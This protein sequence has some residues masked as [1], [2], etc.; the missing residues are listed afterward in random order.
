MRRL[1]SLLLFVSSL[2]WADT[3]S[4]L[5]T[6]TPGVSGAGVWTGIGGYSQLGGQHPITLWGCCTSYSGS[7]PFYDTATWGGNGQSGQFIWSYGQATVQQIIAVN[8]ALANVGAG[9]QISGYNWGYDVRN[10]NGNDGQS[11]YSDVLTATTFMTNTAGAN[12]LSDTRT[13]SGAMEWTRFTGTVS[14]ATPID[15]ANAGVLG[16]KFSSSDAGFW[17]G[18]YGPQVRD[19]S[20]SL[21]YTAAPVDPCVADPQSSPTC[22][23]YR[24]YYTMSDDGYARVDLP[25]AFPF[26]GQVFTTSYMY[27]NGVV[28]FLDN[29]W[30]FCC[31][32][33]NLNNQA[34]TANSPWNYAIYAL[35]TDLIPGPDS[36]FYTQKTD[37][38]TGMKY[39]WEIVPEIGTSL[40]NTFSVQIKDSGFIGL[41]YDQVNLNDYRQPLIC[42][43]GDISN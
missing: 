20:L 25:F 2:A 5:I 32:G 24:T 34:F 10:M 15:L 27:T 13:Y 4:N 3:T 23:G 28:G 26:Y 21:N 42:I 14:A 6:N 12:L 41:S 33:T 31:D 37:N 19:V 8:Q 40:N 29:N 39:T 18:Y 17:A 1:L 36:R 35:N 9:V 43:A 16:I 7:A 11:S 22:A 38:N 30:G